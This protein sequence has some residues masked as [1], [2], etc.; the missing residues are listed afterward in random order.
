MWKKAHSKNRSLTQAS[1]YNL[2]VFFFSSLFSVPIS[3]Y[4]KYI[5]R[6]VERFEA[7]NKWIK[8]VYGFSQ[9]FYENGRILFPNEKHK[10]MRIPKVDPEK[11]KKE[12]QNTTGKYT[13]IEVN[14][15]RYTRKTCIKA[16][17][18][19][20]IIFCC[21]LLLEKSI[22]TIE[23]VCIARHFTHIN[24]KCTSYKAKATEANYY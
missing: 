21:C 17:V 20:T 14:D 2:F 22:E 7:L 5:F 16:T 18:I 19:I 24:F 23:G 15:S 6:I 8:Q 9:L 13:M 1:C 3:P 11:Q 10:K 4:V 12:R